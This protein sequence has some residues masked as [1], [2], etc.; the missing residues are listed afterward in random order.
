[1]NFFQLNR[2][3]EKLSQGKYTHLLLSLIVFFLI[4][5]ILPDNALTITFL[6]FI[7]VV[8]LLL[9][10]RTFEVTKKVKRIFQYLAILVI[11]IDLLTLE[12]PSNLLTICLQ[13]IHLLITSLFM[14]L[15]IVF[16][17]KKLFQDKKVDLA[18]IQGGVSVYFLLG[19]LWFFWY[20][21]LYL[22]EPDSFSLISANGSNQ[23]ELLYFSFTTLTTLGYGD[24]S[25]VN[26][27]AMT[28]TNF[29]A[30]VGQMYPVIFIARLVSLYESNN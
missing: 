7:F 23:Y 22:I 28:L 10:V 8:N 1:M 17:I 5:S 6:R 15:A 29:E 30:I 14:L 9:V 2:Y 18:T 20:K 21:I 3:W 13:F 11:F 27:F 12:E 26:N 19:F 4:A 25:P 16:L 24:I